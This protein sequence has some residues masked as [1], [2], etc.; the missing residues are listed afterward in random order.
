MDTDDDKDFDALFKVTVEMT[1]MMMRR[2]VQSI[3]SKIMTEI[4]WLIRYD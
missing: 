1:M 4:F 3:V 2:R